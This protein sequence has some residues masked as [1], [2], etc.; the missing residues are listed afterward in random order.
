MHRFLRRLLP[1]HNYGFI[2][3]CCIRGMMK[4]YF[5]LRRVKYNA[6]IPLLRDRIRDLFLHQLLRKEFRWFYYRCLGKGTFIGVVVNHTGRRNIMRMCGK[7]LIV[8][9]CIQRT[10]ICNTRER[11]FLMVAIKYRIYKN[12]KR[13]SRQQ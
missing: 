7:I 5:L 8:R 1:K 10:N 6:A 11:K 13:I 4:D 2:N 9:H 12:M 3:E